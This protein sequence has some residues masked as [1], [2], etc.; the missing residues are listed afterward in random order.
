MK[1]II[2]IVFFCLIILSV[3]AQAQHI[4]SFD[5]AAI[6]NI[7]K[8]HT[9]LNVSSFYHF[10]KYLSAGIEVN[11]FFPVD[12]TSEGEEIKISA[13]DIDLNL[14][15]FIPLYKKLNLYPITGISHTSDKEVN[16][17]TGDSRYESFWSFNTGTGILWASEKWSPHIEYL[18]TWGQQNQ[19]FLLAGISYELELG[20]KKSEKKEVAFSAVFPKNSP[21]KKY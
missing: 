9:G 7:Q 12:R 21:L 3:T 20:K 10:N 2:R 5:M 17:A 18:F 19:Q 11:R 16:R 4:L 1:K 13:W 6:R 14:H 8:I 15:Y